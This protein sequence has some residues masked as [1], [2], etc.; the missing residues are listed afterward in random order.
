MSACGTY[1]GYAR[2]HRQ[3][4]A[5]CDPCRDAARE[6]QRA[7]RAT[8][9]GTTDANRRGNRLRWKAMA[10]LRRRHPGEY[11]DILFALEAEAS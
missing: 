1:A 4:E 9:S 11:M 5:P 6:Y 10:E 3:G 8:H 2:H 7:Y